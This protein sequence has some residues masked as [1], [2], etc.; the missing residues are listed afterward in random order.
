MIHASGFCSCREQEKQ[1]SFIRFVRKFCANVDHWIRG[2]KLADWEL[3]SDENRSTVD[4]KRRI[5]DSAND[6]TFD[7]RTVSLSPLSERNELIWCDAKQI[8]GRNPTEPSSHFW[9]SSVDFPIRLKSKTWSPRCTEKTFFCSSRNTS[10]G[11]L[12][13]CTTTK[14]SFGLLGSSIDQRLWSSEEND[15]DERDEQ[16]SDAE[17]RSKQSSS[18]AAKFKSS[19]REFSNGFW[20]IFGS[21]WKKNDFL[22][23]VSLVFGSIVNSKSSSRSLNRLV[24]LTVLLSDSSQLSEE[25]FEKVDSIVDDSSRLDQRFLARKVRSIDSPIFYLSFDFVRRCRSIFVQEKSVERAVSSASTSIDVNIG[26]TRSSL[27]R[28]NFVRCATVF[29]VRHR[30]RRREPSFSICW[31]RFGVWKEFRPLTNR[32]DRLGSRFVVVFE[33]R[34]LFTVTMRTRCVERPTNICFVGAI[35][36]R[37]TWIDNV[38]VQRR[39]RTK[40]VELKKFSLVR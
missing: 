33:G 15:E 35:V 30:T 23:E 13:S 25:I 7:Q 9:T 14:I 10:L 26:R 39:T 12:C 34:P 37:I 16:L 19:N 4:P 40:F 17:N 24:E 31:A 27:P 36:F 6:A 1:Q 38:H 21:N 3:I 18:I 28:R 2:W 5:E 20:Q 8:W 22:D 11:L 32:V 29:N